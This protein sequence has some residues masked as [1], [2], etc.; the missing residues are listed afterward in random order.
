MGE[1]HQA[2]LGLNVFLLGFVVDVSNINPPAAC[3]LATLVNL[4]QSKGEQCC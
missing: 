4:T 2:E 1:L 3:D